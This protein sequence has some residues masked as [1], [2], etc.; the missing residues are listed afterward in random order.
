[1]AKV[2]RLTDKGASVVKKLPSAGKGRDLHKEHQYMVK[3][4]AELFGWRAKLEE[5]IPRSLESVDV[6]FDKDDIRIAVEISSTTTPEH[7]VQN[8][9]KCLDAGYDYIL[10]VCDDDKRLSQLKTEVKKAFSFKKREWI[11]FCHAS[12]VKEFFSSVGP[13]DIV[14]EKGIVSDQIRKQKQQMD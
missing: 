13:K 2:L 4:Q 7:E 5:R 12:R 1:L 6:G 8:I 14:S 11:R 9:R 3:E 10:A